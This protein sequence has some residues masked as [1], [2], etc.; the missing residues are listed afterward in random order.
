MRKNWK[1]GKKND[2]IE[3]KYIVFYSPCLILSFEKSGNKEMLFPVPAV[4]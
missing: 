1:K 3:K 4:Y 2:S